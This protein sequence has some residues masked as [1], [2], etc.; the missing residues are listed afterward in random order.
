M[1]CRVLIGFVCWLVGARVWQ[2][3]EASALDALSCILLLLIFALSHCRPLPFPG[4]LSHTVLTLVP[5]HSHFPNPPSAHCVTSHYTTSHCVTSH[6]TTS[7]TK[8][9]R[10]FV[11]SGLATGASVTRRRD[12]AWQQSWQQQ[13]ACEQHSTARG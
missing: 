1:G 12:S 11:A 13:G 8:T 3:D 9:N 10:R 4:L 5:T 7:H 6:Y 2:G